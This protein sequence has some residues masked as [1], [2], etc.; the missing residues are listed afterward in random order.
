M[1]HVDQLAQLETDEVPATAQVIP[2]RN[3]QR[4]DVL[5]PETALT[6]QQA[7]ANAPQAQLG[8]FRV[9]RIIGEE[10]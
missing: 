9:P 8:F 6:Q 10:A 7:L 3:V 5:R 2:S 1:S 4:R